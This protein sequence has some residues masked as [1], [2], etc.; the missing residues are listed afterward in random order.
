MF[1]ITKKPSKT[2][3]S[4]VET[5]KNAEE[6]SDSLEIFK[7]LSFLILAS[8]MGKMRVDLFKNAVTKN[9]ASL[10]DENQSFNESEISESG[11]PTHFIIVE[12]QSIKTWESL[13]KILSKKK[14]YVSIKDKFE[15]YFKVLTS[16]WLSECLK[17]KKFVEIEKKYE[18]TPE[19]LD[20]KV[21]EQPEEA[22]KKKAVYSE[23]L[24]S[25]L[26]SQSL[27][28][29]STISTNKL[30][31]NFRKEARKLS[32]SDT[33]EEVKK[34]AK[35]NFENNDDSSY[36]DS[37]DETFRLASSAQDYFENEL[38]SR[39]NNL[40]EHNKHWTCAHSSKE[41]PSNVNKHITDKLEEM[42]AIYENTKD[43]FRALGYQKA[44]IALKRCSTPIK[45]YEEASKLP[46]VGKRIADK[47]WEIVETGDLKSLDE[48]NSRDDISS[49][50]LFTQIH[51]IGPT[52]AQSFVSQGFR[53]LDDLRTKA[54]LT[55]QQ[56][57]GLQYYH[58]FIQRIPRDEVVK[59]EKI[60]KTTALNI[61]SGLI[62]ETC[63]SYRRGKPTCGDVD[64]LIT[65]PDGVSH[66]KIFGKLIEQLH[67]IGFLTDDL[68][69]QDEN[70]DSQRKYLGVCQLPE[71]NSLHR[72]L[73][74]I[75]VPYDEFGCAL[76]YFTGSAHFN[77]SMR[78][79][80]R[81]LGMSLCEKS[82]NKNVIRK[83]T[84]KINL[85]EKIST[86]TE[87]DVFRVLN[88]T[89]RPPRERDF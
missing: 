63:G 60:V 62:V 46:G 31:I 24:F 10:L 43:K 49:I 77:R 13:E 17:L 33:D 9:G 56:K 37:D 42:S 48:Y 8:G 30:S 3:S 5:A 50:K 7:N 88:L 27:V 87:E 22:N 4:K 51:G 73:D 2:T 16:Q 69:V 58:E 45:T 32:N 83:G 26:E 11:Q 38:K 70:S 54:H 14:F 65:H 59:I 39:V 28:S 57:I 53:T 36:S 47:I 29:E 82:L 41:Q 12:E 80:A 71:P 44:I 67:D 34:R 6:K 35:T 66:K 74:I 79:L 72:R 20:K 86:P 78:H 1:R 19:N 75:V 68:V 15:L 85:G 64:I 81:K 21:V 61:N 89:Y 55:R 40:L 84:E 76:L 25:N 18:I 52:S 23:K